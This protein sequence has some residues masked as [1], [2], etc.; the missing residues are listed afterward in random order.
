LWVEADPTKLYS[1]NGTT[2]VVANDP[3]YLAK[4]KSSAVRNASEA[5]LAQRPLYKTDLSKPSLLFDG[6][7]DWLETAGGLSWG[8]GSGQFW[9]AVS[10]Q[11]ASTSGYQELVTIYDSVGGTGYVSDLAVS[12]GVPLFEI[13]NVAGSFESDTQG[14]VSAG[15]PFVLIA[16]ATTSQVQV[17]LDGVSGGATSLT[18][19]LRTNTANLLVGSQNGSDATNGRIFGACHGTGT[20]SS[21][22]RGNLQTYLAGLHP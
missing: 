6:S 19:V 18:G 16:T 8:D 5:T 11:L 10:A 14:S 2:L 13:R 22:D 17:Y 9:V 7:N 3:V 15:T 4:D 21:T 12:S 1:D 20:L